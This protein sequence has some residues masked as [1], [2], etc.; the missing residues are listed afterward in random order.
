MSARFCRNRMGRGLAGGLP[1]QAP[2]EGGQP[3]ASSPFAHSIQQSRR[4]ASGDLFSGSLASHIE[5]K[6]SMAS[7]TIPVPI[8]IRRISAATRT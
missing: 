6:S 3:F 1:W 2:S 8:A 5:F 4:R 7:I